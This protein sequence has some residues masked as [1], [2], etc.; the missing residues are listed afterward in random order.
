M[1]VDLKQPKSVSQSF[2]LEELKGLY[3]TGDVG[4]AVQT[5]VRNAVNEINDVAFMH[6]LEGRATQYPP[7]S[8]VEKLGTITRITEGQ[9][10]RELI[11]DLPNDC[12]ELLIVSAGFRWR[13][14]LGSEVSFLLGKAI[15]NPQV[16][17]IYFLGNIKRLGKLALRDEITAIDSPGEVF[18]W[19]H[20]DGSYVRVGARP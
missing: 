5:A 12:H 19:V 16:E 20:P 4:A 6:D 11:D 14:H 15:E 7:T 3:V 10:K 8:N 1:S 13:R 9:Y 2:E 17:S 18:K